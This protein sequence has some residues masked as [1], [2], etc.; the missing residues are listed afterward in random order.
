MVR[1]RE[2]DVSGEV[3]RDGVPI[4]YEVFGSGPTTVVLMGTF[5][6]VDGRQWKAQVP[7]LARHVR[8]VTVDP[9]GNGGSGRPIGSAAYA[10]DV[11]ADDALAVMD[12]TGTASAFLVALCSG[13]KWSML[14]AHA[15]PHRVRGLVAI[16]AGVHPLAPQPDPVDPVDAPRWQDDYEGWARYH[17]ALMVPEPHSSKVYDDL[18]E[19]TLQT[20]GPT[21]AAR[22]YADLSP[23]T[24]A[25]AVAMAQGLTCPVLVLHGTEDRCQPIAR[26]ARFAEVSGG[27]LVVLEGAGHLPHAR[28]PVVVNRL[29]KEF[30][31]E[32]SGARRPT[33][34]TVTWSTA[35]VR[36]RRALWVCSP[37]GLGHALRDLEIAKALRAEVPD[38]RIEWLAQSPVSAV[39]E[40]EG[41]VVHP[42]SA[43]LA[44]ESAHWESEAG[45]HDLHAFHAFRRMDEIL[46]A[47]YMLFDDVVREAPYDLWVGDEAWE[48]DHFLHENPE[49]KIAPYAFLT[50]V[51]GF[52]P[53]DPEGDPR[54]AELCADYNA[55]IVEHRARF[56][57]VRDRSVFIGGYDELPD[58][59]LGPG[60][61]TVRDWTR[62]QFTSVPYVLPFAPSTYRRTDA[63]RRRLGYGTGYPL[64]V[65]AVGGTAV[66]R[67]LLEL[68]AE[69]FAL[70]RKEQPDARMVMVTGPRLDPGLLPD[71]DG[72]ERLGY[73]PRLFEHLACADVAVVQGGLSTTME[74]TAARRPFVYFPLAHHWE[75]Q[76]FVAHRLD[77]FGA[78]VRM[79]YA[80]TTP[81]EL[82]EAM[83]TA[84]RSRPDYRRI[85]PGGARRAARHLAG[86]L[87]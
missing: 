29:I 9:R 64:Y 67:S 8:V 17:S 66:G 37:I 51:V 26:S 5:P 6:V 30:L 40:A 58:A 13:I 75:Q 11:N 33:R 14:I 60:L 21:I 53:V 41:E 47:N 59:S 46:C 36:P 38:L 35:R 80:R 2:P 73:V 34:P 85:Q 83:I 25:D 16:A 3:D 42:A 76:H 4:H 20:D 57:A 65:A 84:G 71:V 7:Y 81:P 18:V 68:T 19:W 55:E 44:S 43:E 87:R 78:G 12:A 63:L 52:L 31:D 72:L 61:P 54:E 10:D 24:E 1:A 27:R 79:D 56:P 62:E 50:D 86:L 45:D 39:L 70:V 74:L 77:H 32:H 48:V 69:A 22:T 15:A 28:H 49:R 23:A 82:A